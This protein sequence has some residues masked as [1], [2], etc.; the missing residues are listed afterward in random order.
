MAKKQKK[1]KTKKDIFLEWLKEEK[2]DA[3]ASACG[4]GSSWNHAF[5]Q[6]L[7]MVYRKANK[8]L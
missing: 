4:S 6:A 3:S 7:N 8:T 1:R 2:Q 5:S